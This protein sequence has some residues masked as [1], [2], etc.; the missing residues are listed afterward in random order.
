MVSRAADFLVAGLADLPADFVADLAAVR[1]T[2][3]LAHLPA[4]DVAV[5]LVDRLAH[6]VAA[7]LLAAARDALADAVFHVLVAALDHRFA[8]RAGDLF[9][10]GPVTRLDAFLDNV[11]APL[12]LALTIHRLAFFFPAGPGYFFVDRLANGLVAGMPPLLQ[13]GVINESVTNSIL[14]LA[15][16]EAALCVA[17]GI[18]QHGIA[19]SA[20]F[21]RR[22]GLNQP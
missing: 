9:P 6:G 11:L 16:G 2:D 8:H 19:D 22:R 17:I 3:H 5:L 4:M 15:R 20:A 1:F 21:R 18:P 13:H 14:L 12:D 7:F 10:A